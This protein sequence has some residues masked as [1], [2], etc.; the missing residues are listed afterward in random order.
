[1]QLLALVAGCRSAGCRKLAA[2]GG[3]AAA[4]L[5][6]MQVC[7]SV[8]QCISLLLKKVTD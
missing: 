4:Q 2:G 1:M 7:S 6:A 8:N 5:A 3:A